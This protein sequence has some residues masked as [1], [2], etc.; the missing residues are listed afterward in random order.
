LLAPKPGAETARKN[1]AAKING[2]PVDHIYQ[3]YDGASHLQAVRFP[4]DNG[5]DTEEATGQARDWCQAHDGSF[6]AM[7]S[8]GAEAPEE[9]RTAPVEQP[10]D[11]HD[12]MVRIGGDGPAPFSHVRLMNWK[13]NNLD[14]Q[15][16]TAAG[17]ASTPEKDTYEEI[18]LPG[19]FRRSLSSFMRNPVLYWN[20]QWNTI[21][22]GT[23]IESWIDEDMG[24]WA[25]D[26]FGTTT[27]AEEVWRAVA[28]DKSVRSMSI[29]FDGEYSPEYGY[30]D[31]DADAWIWTDLELIEIS[32]VGM[33]ACPS[34]QFQLSRTLGLPMIKSYRAL[35]LPVLRSQANVWDADSV[36]ARLRKH[37]L[38]NER[39]L[40]SCYLFDS[41]L[42]LV[43]IVEGEARLA[44]PGVAVAMATLMGARGGVKDMG[45]PTKRT[46]YRVLRRC[47]EK[48]G[49]PMPT[50]AGEWPNGFRD[51][52]FHAGE[53]S[54]LEKAIAL[55]NARSVVTGA[56]SLANITRHWDGEGG[57]PFAEVGQ[58]AYDAV[59]ELLVV[60][61]SQPE[62]VATDVNK[63]KLLAALDQ[64]RDAG[65]GRTD[66]GSPVI[67]IR[68]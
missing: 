28:I 29:G 11:L 58:A 62:A 51:V 40:D 43:D 5:W 15:A 36:D 41:Q 1:G 35:E 10:P 68:G 52:T 57:E 7:K 60:L 21:P 33:P 39:M 4:R 16:R 64:L 2:K 20:H 54:I 17:W 63:R 49:Q 50:W 30:F 47:Y 34:A 27:L 6:E 26:K 42:P 31:R 55:H 12:L 32:A 13:T 38:G 24:L 22:I 45:M 18:I 8:E 25:N 46:T 65:E 37:A 23:V 3:V 9:T 59:L 56:R 67:R 19:A 53:L 61:K 48:F 66:T 14:L 44:W